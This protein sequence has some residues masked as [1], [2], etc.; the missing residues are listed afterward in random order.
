MEGG[1]S[2]FRIS[3]I[4]KEQNQKIYMS[5][6]YGKILKKSFGFAFNPKRW[7]PFF[8]LDIVFISI[9]MLF[10]LANLSTF[11]ALMVTMNTEPFVV[12]SFAAEIAVIVVIG[13]V[14]LLL[15]LWLIG[16][17]VRQSHK[18][19]ELGGSYDF[20]LKK[21][22]SLFA[23]TVIVAVVTCILSAIPYIGWLFAII[24]SLVFFFVVQSVIVGGNNFSNALMDSWS[25]FKKR[26]VHVLSVWIIIII[27]SLAI[28]AIFAIPMVVMMWGELAPN[29]MYL[30]DPSVLAGL[31]FFLFTNLHVLII[32]GVILLAGE[33]IIIALTLKI[34]TEFYIKL[35][36]KKLGIF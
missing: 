3:H 13:A 32:G 35:R 4:Y 26:P 27:L 15:R 28:I 2:K 8:A 33:A 18:E 6:E 1:G 10:V 30:S 11:V 19:K 14:W 5:I 24:A 22:P 31:L 21:Y 29:I 36:K 17:A 34:Q 12:G 16:A 23:V 20:A 9:I 25:I 7:L